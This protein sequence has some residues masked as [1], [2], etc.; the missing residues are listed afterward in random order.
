MIIKT[1]TCLAFAAACLAITV[2]AGAQTGGETVVVTPPPRVD[3]G[4]VNWN[5]LAN[6]KEAQ[7]Y[8]R[9]LETNPAFRM[10]RIQKECGPITDPQLHADCVTSFNQFEPMVASATAPQRVASSTRSHPHQ[11]HYVG[12]STAPRHYQSHYGR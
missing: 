3:P 6:L 11:T 10:A 2:P 4:D 12:S 5:P 1:A 8:D 9:L 7:Q